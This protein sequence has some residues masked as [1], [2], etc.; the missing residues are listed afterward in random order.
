MRAPITSLCFER[1]YS[2][3]YQ[4][5][6]CDYDRWLTWRCINWVGDPVHII[7]VQVS[8]ICSFSF[9]DRK[10]TGSV[11]FYSELGQGFRFR[12]LISGIREKPSDDDVDCVISLTKIAAHRS[13]YSIQQDAFGVQEG[14]STDNRYIKLEN[15]SRRSSWLEQAMRDNL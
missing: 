12:R 10:A 1:L 11:E 3:E 13:S 9:F 8:V 5:K 7:P 15:L 4:Q 6:Q 14:E 2:G